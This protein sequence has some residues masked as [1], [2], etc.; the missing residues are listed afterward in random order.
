MEILIDG[1]DAILEGEYIDPDIV[2]DCG[3]CF[4]FKK[5]DDIWQGVAHERVLRV[6]DAPEGLRL[7]GAADDA[8]TIWRGYFDAD[9]SYADI[10]KL[11]SSDEAVRT[12]A[13]TFKGMRLLRQQPFETLISFIISAN[14]NIKRIMGIIDKLCTLAGK[15]IAE[16]F[17]AF[18]TP[19]AIAALTEQQL[20][21]C[22][23]GYRAPYII[24]TAGAVADGIDLE[25]LRTMDYLEAK[26]K[27]CALK[28]VG[29]KV[30]D[31]I[32]LFSLDH[33]CAFPQ[34]VWIKRALKEIYGVSFKNDKEL[35]TFALE[36]FGENAGIAQQ[37]IFHYARIHGI[38]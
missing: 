29:P 14:N 19:E 1:R 23:A 2:F 33:G 28:G 21:E 37:Y 27:L 13:E 5:T 30:A 8:E 7:I 17:Y 11:I 35:V 16:G 36:H 31:C 18:P 24:E 32:L 12:S 26:S 3:Q 34:D 4:R 6:K 22:G 15:E 25:A 10:L 38:K 9:R 20:V